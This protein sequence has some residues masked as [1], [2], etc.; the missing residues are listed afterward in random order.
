M[1]R[2]WYVRIVFLVGALFVF[3]VGAFSVF[4]GV[5][6]YLA[7]RLVCSTPTFDFG[8]LPS[9]TDV[10]HSFTLV[11]RG[12]SRARIVNIVPSCSC[13]R[14]A[15]TTDVL[16]PGEETQVDVELSLRGLSG[17]I[18]KRILLESTDGINPI[19]ELRVTGEVLPNYKTSPEKLIWDHSDRTMCFEIEEVSQEGAIELLNVD[20]T[21]S[22]IQ[23]QWDPIEEGHR[24][25]VVLKK[26]L[27]DLQKDQT[28]AE[29]IWVRIHTSHPFD[30]DFLVPVDVL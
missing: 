12:R 13:S 29:R 17:R 9:G 1:S 25:R 8:A 26:H 5:R 14:A 20:S 28:K 7:P 2:I 23:S 19:T 27:R 6:L 3:A 21:G 18:N 15:P 16:A 22:W 4:R 24:Y 11:N 30:P 10:Q